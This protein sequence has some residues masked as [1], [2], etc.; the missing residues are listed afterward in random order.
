[1][2]FINSPSLFGVSRDSL[3]WLGDIFSH[4]TEPNGSRPL[5]CLKMT[6]DGVLHL[7]KSLDGYFTARRSVAVEGARALLQSHR[8]N[9]T[10]TRFLRPGWR[11]N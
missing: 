4:H 3:T 5:R 2:S 10:P 8:A 7:P 9:L 11:R 1:M 6:V